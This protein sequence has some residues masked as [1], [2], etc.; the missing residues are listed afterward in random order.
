MSF[1]FPLG[2]IALAGIPVLI[3][4]YIIK[5]KYTE[6]TIA[7]TYIWR[8]SEKFLKRRKPISK[9]TGIL[10]LILQ[11]LAI[12]AVAFLIAHPVFTIPASANDFY[13]ILD[14]SASMNME[15]DGSTRFEKAQ[16]E[17]CKIINSSHGGSTYSLVFASDTTYE[18]FESITDKEQAKA[19]VKEL[20]ASW[21]DTDCTSA[22]VYAQT[23]FTGNRS[24]LMYLLSDKPYDTG[25]LTLINVA[26]GECNSAFVEYKYTRSGMGVVASGKVVSYDED[27][28]LTVELSAGTDGATEVEKIGQ[29]NVEAKKG[30]PVDFAISGVVP[31]FNSLQL[32]IVNEDALMDD[33]VVILYDEAKK[34]ARKVLL[35]T[36]DVKD[37]TYLTGAIQGAG[38]ASVETVSSKQYEDGV[39]GSYGLY[40]FNGYSPKELPKNVA[41]WLVNAIDG[42]GK[43]S[44]ISYRGEQ[45]PRDEEGPDSYYSPKYTK[46]TSTQEKMFME[47]LDSIITDRDNPDIVIR[48]YAQYGVPRSFTTIMSIGGDAVISA[49]LNKNN[50]RQVVFAFQLGDSNF[51][52][53]LDFLMLVRNLMNYSFPSVI[54][55]T[56]YVCGDLMTV[57]VVPNCENIV[58]KTPSGSSVTLDTY[59]NDL[60]EF[61]LT[62]TG[63]YTLVVSMKGA[64]EATELFVFARVPETE[65]HNPEDGE[66]GIFILTGIK[67]YKYRDGVYDDLLAFMILIAVL[68]L[69][70]WGVYCY[71]QY[72]LR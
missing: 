65:S 48:K 72:Q 14:G 54:D 41:V 42:S 32:R 20:K 2:L 67:E 60:C 70:D 44:D 56:S 46:G 39:N 64:E 34:E 4:I 6:Q 13:F 7:S 18:V 52:G 12:V 55:N 27:T 17:I 38:N 62:E 40:V 21:N 9:L 33:N 58:V 23:Y 30:E 16:E 31:S 45:T 3:I 8:L 28:V 59:D 25:N 50:D 69:A 37:A 71:E 66:N 29:V 53:K 49:G 1:Q 26:S 57:N 15:S 19:T 47:G 63:T 5:S 10:T 51:G 36:D 35:V 22:I 61:Q 43:G 68:L 24:S 11:I